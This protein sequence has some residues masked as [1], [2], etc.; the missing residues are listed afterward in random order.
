MSK[1]LL[2]H[3]ALPYILMV[4]AV[5]GTIGLTLAALP[6]L[7]NPASSPLASGGGG[8]ADEPVAELPAEGSIH[9]SAPFKRQIARTLVR[10]A[11]TSACAT[12]VTA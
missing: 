8:A 11:L 3:P 12:M 1:K 10:R 2:T 5:V 7:T 6:F 4:A 9:A